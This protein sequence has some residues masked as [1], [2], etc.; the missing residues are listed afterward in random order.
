HIG[1]QLGLVQGCLFLLAGGGGGGI[2]GGDPF[3]VAVLFQRIDGC[4]QADDAG[5][6]EVPA[7]QGFLGDVLGIL[8]VVQ[9]GLGRASVLGNGGFLRGHFAVDD[10]HVLGIVNGGVV[11]GQDFH[12]IGTALVVSAG[13]D[14]G[15]DLRRGFRGGVG[16]IVI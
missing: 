7:A 1:L 6:I 9:N 2:L 4:A 13:V 15:D 11:G 12:V 8:Q 16:Q 5:L 14:V 3:G 10:G